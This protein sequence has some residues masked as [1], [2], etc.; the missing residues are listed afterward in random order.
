MEANGPALKAIRQAQGWSL[1]TLGRAVGLSRS[2]VCRIE[3][4][5]NGTSEE[6]MRRIADALRVPMAAITS[7][8]FPLAA[9]LKSEDAA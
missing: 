2:Q 4:Q 6:R 5:R 8:E 1:T 9:V 7:P 3:S